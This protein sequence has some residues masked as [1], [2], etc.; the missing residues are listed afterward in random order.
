MSILSDI[1]TTMTE[2]DLFIINKQLSECLQKVSE[3]TQ[4]LNDTKIELHNMKN[5][6][7]YLRRVNANLVRNCDRYYEE[8]DDIK[9]KIR[10]F[11]SI[12]YDF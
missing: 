10:Q 3:L 11:E 2:T 9:E 12:Q 8:V 7:S 5:H 1:E 4:E 6:L